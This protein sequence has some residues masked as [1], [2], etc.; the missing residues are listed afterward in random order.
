VLVRRDVWSAGDEAVQG[1]LERIQQHPRQKLI[2]FWRDRDDLERTIRDDVFTLDA[3]SL[4]G[5]A[6][7]DGSFVKVGTTFEQ[8]WA[9]ENCGFV[10][11]DGRSLREMARTGLEAESALVPVPRTAPGA[12]ARIDVRLSTPAE[13][14]SYRSLWKMVGADGSLCFPSTPGV[15]CQVRAVY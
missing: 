8:W 12:A 2:R 4:A 13:P 5:E 7:P 10:T 15:W 14:G 3:A 6:V 1:L 9:L 11:W